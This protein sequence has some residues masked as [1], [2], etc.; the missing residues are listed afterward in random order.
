MKYPEIIW[1]DLIAYETNEIL[2]VCVDVE[3]RNYFIQLANI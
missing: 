3:V 2:L 1:F